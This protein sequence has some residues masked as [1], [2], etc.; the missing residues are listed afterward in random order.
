MPEDKWKNVF[1]KG[2]LISEYFSLESHLK[3][4]CAKSPY[5]TFQLPS[6]YYVSKGI[7]WVGSEK[8]QKCA[9]VI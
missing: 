9:D 8:V 3:R 2:G 6:L 7:G 4:K 5:L 1:N